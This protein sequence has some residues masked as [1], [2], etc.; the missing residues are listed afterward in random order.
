MQ[1]FLPLLLLA[2]PIPA[3][4]LCLLRPPVWATEAASGLTAVTLF[5]VGVWL[6]SATG[7]QAVSIQP[8]IYVDALSAILILVICVV[9]A[10]ALR[11]DWLDFLSLPNSCA[12]ETA[13]K[14]YPRSESGAARAQAIDGAACL[15][16]KVN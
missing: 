7:V 4:L 5:A 15:S 16:G 13:G 3:A 6:V 11:P 12:G 9:G 14:P 10:V 8:G 2:V 1:T